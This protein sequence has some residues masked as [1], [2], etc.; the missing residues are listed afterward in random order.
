MLLVPL[1]MAVVPSLAL[2]HHISGTVYC[3]VDGDGVID[4]PGDTALSGIGVK[5]TSLDAQPGQ[6]FTTTTNGSG[7]YNVN[8]P[9]RT[10]R[11]RVE[12][13]GLPGGWT[14]VVPL[15]GTYTIQIITQSSQDHA[16]NVNFLI[17]GCAPTTTTTSTTSTSTTT[18][19][20][21]TTTTTSTSTTTTSTSTTTT[22][23]TTT[24]T[25]STSTTTTS[26]ATS[27]TTTLCVCPGIPFLTY[28]DAKIGNAGEVYGSLAAN[29]P[30]ARISI[31]KYVFMADGTEVIGDS[32]RILERADV[33]RVLGNTL[34]ISPDATVRDGTGSAT[35]PVVDPFCSLPPLTC[36]GPDVQVLP[37]EDI[38]PLAPGSYGSV[39]VANTGTLRLAPGT[40]DFCQLQ[41]GRSGTVHAEGPTTIN[42]QR[43]VRIGNAAGLLAPSPTTPIHLNVEGKLV[44][45]GQAAHVQAFLTAPNALVRLGRTSLFQ[46]SFC[47][48]ELGNDK[49]IRIECPCTP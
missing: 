30:G 40:F 49:H 9:G 39:R 33:F 12:L 13:T 15:G 4:V 8:L 19:S 22:V 41:V 23:T 20:T 29:Q 42:V 5:M 24:A 28:G 45:M 38:G 1:A 2:A 16:D 34:S 44:R 11:Y 46:G 7:F 27:S 25:T 31:G 26:T 47:I 36:G 18:T 3:D 14:I 17:Q 32:V 35:I 48:G 21:S 10:D 43:T 6:M 37:F